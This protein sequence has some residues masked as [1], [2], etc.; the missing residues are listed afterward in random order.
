MAIIANDFTLAYFNLS[1]GLTSSRLSNN[2]V[3]IVQPHQDLLSSPNETSHEMSV[4][5]L[6]QDWTTTETNTI[7]NE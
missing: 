5:N 6:D 3:E 1:F 7:W 4:N 2:N